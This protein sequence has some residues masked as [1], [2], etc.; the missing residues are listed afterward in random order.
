MDKIKILIL[1]KIQEMRDKKTF[2]DYE[3]LSKENIAS[4]MLKVMVSEGLLC[5]NNVFSLTENGDKVLSNYLILNSQ[6]LI[7]K[8]KICF[9]SNVFD[10]MVSGNLNISDLIALKEKLE[11]YITHIQVDEIN[12]C[13]DKDKRSRLFLIMGKLSPIIIPTTS[14]ILGKS[15]LGE[16]RLGDGHIFEELK[17]GNIKNTE[18]ALIGEVSIK[19]GIILVTQDIKLKKYVNSNN[20]KAINVDEFIIKYLINKNE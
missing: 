6:N 1:Q 18:D 15:R 9:D 13:S 11:Y 12:E 14:F 3:S 5:Y 4:G 2:P 19:E 7:I 8:E 17:N 10:E 16:A 20:G